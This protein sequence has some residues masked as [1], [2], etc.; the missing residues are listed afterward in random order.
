MDFGKTMK[1]GVGAG[2]GM[3]AVKLLEEAHRSQDPIE[4]LGKSAIG[5]AMADIAYNLIK[6][7]ENKDPHFK[8]WYKP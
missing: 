7:E 8:G 6:P 2:I 5:G 4:S 1:R 3:Q